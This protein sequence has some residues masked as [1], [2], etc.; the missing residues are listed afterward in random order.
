MLLLGTKRT[1][2]P[3]LT[4]SVL[5][6]RPEVIGAS[7]I[8][9]FDGGFN[10]SAQHSNLVEKMEYGHEAATSYLLFCGSAV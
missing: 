5:G 10:W 7:L 1:S 6:G 8:G 2:R 4:M 9:A 3:G